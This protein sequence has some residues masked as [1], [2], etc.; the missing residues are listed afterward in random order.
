MRAGVDEA[1]RGPVLGPLVVAGVRGPADA[2]PEDVD[3][4]KA[5]DAD[6]RAR[7]ADA[8]R[9]RDELRVAVRR[10]DAAE[11]NERMADGAT[12]NTLEAAAFADVLDELGAGRALVDAVGTDAA[13]F[14]AD[15]EERLAPADVRVEARKRA[16]ATDP[17]VGAA[18]IVA[19]RARDRRVDALAEEVGEPIG[20]GYPSDPTTRAF[21]EAWRRDHRKPPAFARRA[22]STLDDLGFGT[23]SL[24]EFTGGPP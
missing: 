20:S 5:L 13:A 6:T 3:D 1:G 12:M 16:D 4:S 2:V 18:S 15:L 19:K 24:S 11:I 23:R 7:L 17:L 14:A 22:W 8:V 9:A 10:V 21:L